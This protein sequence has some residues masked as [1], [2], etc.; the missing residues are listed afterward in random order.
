M[1]RLGRL[2][3]G[4]WVD[5]GFELELG[6]ACRAAVRRAG[7]CTRTRARTWTLLLGHGQKA[8]V[9]R[10]EWRFGASCGG[11]AVA[12]VAGGL[13]RSGRPVER[14]VRGSNRQRRRLASM[15]EARASAAMAEG[16]PLCENDAEGLWPRLLP[17]TG[18]CCSTAAPGSCRV[19]L[20]ISSAH[21]PSPAPGCG[22]RVH[23]R[24]PLLQLHHLP[25]LPGRPSH[26]NRWVG[27][28]NPPPA[29]APH[30]TR[31]PTSGQQACACRP[32]P[33]PPPQKLPGSRWGPIASLASLPPLLH[34][35]PTGVRCS[36][37]AA[38]TPHEAP[39]GRALRTPHAI[40]VC[41]SSWLVPRSRER[42]WP[43]RLATA[44]SCKPR[45]YRPLCASHV[46]R[47]RH[48]VVE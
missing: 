14:G 39:P 27:G 34:A 6:A 7:T 32:P 29:H 48:C 37:P 3:V 20:D 47:R 26:G 31:L 24:A 16:A 42:Q 5:V 15:S 35:P 23:P 44:P 21:G 1:G 10:V 36:A 40:A 8:G 45:I 11:I 46:A 25:A 33:P 17:L 30:P 38:F 18:L 28:D 19:V 12:T 13:C 4:S 41:S 9:A 2:P 22:R 43:R